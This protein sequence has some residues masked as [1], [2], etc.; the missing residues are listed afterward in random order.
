MLDTTDVW[1]AVEDALNFCRVRMGL[2][3][4][5]SEPSKY[6]AVSGYILE[7]KP[8]SIRPVQT[9]GLE[10][11]KNMVSWF[12]ESSVASSGDE[13]RPVSVIKRVKKVGFANQVIKR[14]LKNCGLAK[15]E[16]ILDKARAR[17]N[18]ADP[19]PILSYFAEETEFIGV[20]GDVLDGKDKCGMLWLHI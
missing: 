14:A 3:P 15:Q 4:Y 6:E 13:Y 20:D 9:R 1:Q 19:N 7:A 10:T 8:I 5:Y 18:T 11:K 16:D 17:R 2:T 12:S